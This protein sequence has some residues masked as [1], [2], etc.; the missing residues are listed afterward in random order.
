MD[1]L[2]AA[3][4]GESPHWWVRMLVPARPAI[5]HARTFH[6]TARE[7]ALNKLVTL[8]MVFAPA[9]SALAVAFA[10][11]EPT[12]WRRLVIAAVVT[13]LMTVTLIEWMRFRRHG[14]EAIRVPINLYLMALG[15]LGLIFATGGVFSPLMPALIATPFV[16]A[17]LYT[18]RRLLHGQIAIL[19]LALWA[20]AFAHARWML[21]PVVFGEAPALEH[22]AAP[23][24]AAFGYTAAVIVASRMG[25]AVRGLFEGLVTEALDERDERLGMY[26]EQTSALTALSAEIAHELKNPLTSVKGLAALVAKD[27]EGKTEE[28]LAVLRREVDRMQDILDERLEFSRPLVPLSMQEVD[29]TDLAREVARLHEGSA[30]ERDVTL[31]VEGG[32]APITCDARK[33]R[34]VMVNLVQNALEASSPGGEVTIRVEAGDMTTLHVDDRGAGLDPAVSGRLFEAGVTSKETGSGIGLVVARSLA[35]QHGGDLVLEEREGPGCRATLTL[36][37]TA[38]PREVEA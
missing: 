27:V 26:A 34:Q 29:A 1:P 32:P 24:A 13:L 35:R 30:V 3:N 15:Q 8:R 6:R 25:R 14:I 2:G 36:P 17:L 23:W 33:V 5:T 16:G 11:F 21:L 20:L 18:D 4:I 7:L 37:R 10:I 28:R 38:P 19:V 12:T 22:G 9:L 31:R